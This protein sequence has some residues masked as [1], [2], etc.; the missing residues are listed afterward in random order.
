MFIFNKLPEKQLPPKP[1]R[2]RSYQ[3]KSFTCL[4]GTWCRRSR[5][6]GTREQSNQEDVELLT[7]GIAPFN[8]APHA[9]KRTG[10]MGVLCLLFQSLFL[11]GDPLISVPS[12]DRQG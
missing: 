7:D 6:T 11:G 10:R 3:E 4:S 12:S 5:A 8:P 9:K 1:R 2:G